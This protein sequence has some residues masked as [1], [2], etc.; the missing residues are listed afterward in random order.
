MGLIY[1]FNLI[2]GT[3]ALTLPAAFAKAGWLL[4]LVLIILLAFIGFVTVTFII[5]SIACAN[6]T[7]QWKKLQSHKID[8]VS[9][10]FN[11]I[12]FHFIIYFAK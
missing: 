5:E 10:F 6:A 12:Y 2:V 9:I 3:G 11:K 1:V 7:L 4:S 8:G